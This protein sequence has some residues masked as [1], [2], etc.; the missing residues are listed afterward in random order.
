MPDND[1]KQPQKFQF[2][3]LQALVATTW[4]AI[5][6]LWLPVLP[7]LLWLGLFLGPPAE[8]RR[9]VRSVLCLAAAFYLPAPLC[10]MA[11][12]QSHWDPHWA[13]DQVARDYLWD[14]PC[15]PGFLAAAPITAIWHVDLMHPVCQVAMGVATLMVL[16]LV[17]L[18]ARI[19]IAILIGLAVLAFGYSLF[20]SVAIP[21]G[22]R[23]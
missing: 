2:T 10:I 8:R 11:S 15:L 20:M 22:M 12:Q 4:L 6:F 1:A 23:M 18:L 19:Q 7:V 16:S 21:A 14:A 9:N 13:W 17:T 5:G 3:L